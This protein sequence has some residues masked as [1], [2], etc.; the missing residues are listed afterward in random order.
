MSGG[1]NTLHFTVN[2]D[3]TRAEVDGGLI[4]E[5]QLDGASITLTLKE[6]FVDASDSDSMTI[7]FSS[8]GVNLE[9]SGVV[10]NGSG[11]VQMDDAGGTV[12]AT[13][14]FAV[15]VTSGT[16]ADTLTGGNQAD[17]LT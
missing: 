16:G 13:D 14:N 15:N 11:A 4:D 2:A 9:L 12:S 10:L 6:S 17:T 3:V 5:I 8:N 7:N 1:T